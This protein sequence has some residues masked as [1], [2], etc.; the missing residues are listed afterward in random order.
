MTE[1]VLL[2]GLPGSGKSSF[3]QQR[4]A[5]THVHVS[6]DLMKSAR[7]KNERQR[8]MIGQA[9]AHGR[10]A[11]VDNTNLSRADRAPLLQLARDHGARTV[12]F[13]FDAPAQECVA[14]NASRSGRARVPAIAIWAAARKLQPPDAGERFDETWRVTLG[15]AA[16]DVRPFA[17]QPLLPL[18]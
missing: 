2:I 7:D 1:L 14:R 5:A 8:R 10:S 4:Y 17:P 16:F 3:V 15:P 9:L 12:A 11:V 6:K 18:G 13:F